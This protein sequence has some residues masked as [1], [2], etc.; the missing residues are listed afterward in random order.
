MKEALSV[1]NT[2]VDF[3]FEVVVSI[4]LVKKTPQKLLIQSKCF[5]FS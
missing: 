1:E 3:E 5:L 4:S 2:D